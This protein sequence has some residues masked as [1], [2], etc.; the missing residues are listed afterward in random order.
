LRDHELK[1]RAEF[2]LYRRALED[3]NLDVAEPL[4]RRLRKLSPWVPSEI[5]ELK[6]FRTLYTPP[7]AKR[8]HVARSQRTAS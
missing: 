1:F 3:H 7:R 4:A 5:E 8:R 6:A 2:R